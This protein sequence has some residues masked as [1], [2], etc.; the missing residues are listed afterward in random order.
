MFEP[1]LDEPSIIID[2]KWYVVTSEL[3]CHRTPI[4]CL[5]IEKNHQLAQVLTRFNENIPSFCLVLKEHIDEVGTLA[6]KLLHIGL[7]VRT[8]LLTIGNNP[9]VI[10]RLNRNWH[11]GCV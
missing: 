10:Y 11:L 8:G 9:E 1:L 5:M 3:Y 7:I 4:V 2:G 6:D